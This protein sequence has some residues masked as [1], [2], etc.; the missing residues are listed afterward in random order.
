MSQDRPNI[1]L[2]M[3]DE[4]DPGVMG[5]YGDKLGAT[6]HLDQLASNGIVFDNAYCNSPLC[7]P[8][9]LSFTSGRYVSRVGAWN[10]HCRL[11]SDDSPS[12]AHALNAA[13][14]QSF[15]CGKQHYDKRHSYGFQRL[16]PGIDN[17]TM[18]GQGGFRRAADDFTPDKESW[19]QRAR[20]IRTGGLD[21]SYVLRQDIPV[22]HT[23]RGFLQAR[24]P[25]D[26][27]FFLMAGFIAPHFPLIVPESLHRQ[28]AG[29][30]PMPNLPEDFVER[31]PR[32]YRH[33]RAGF[34]LTEADEA[35][36]RYGRELYWALVH[37]VD[38]LVGQLLASLE[39]S[40]VADNTV[41]IYTSDHGENKG[42]H[43][44]WWKNSMHEQSARV[45]LLVS[46]PK[47]WAGGQRRAS[48][49]S[50]VD[51]VRTLLDLGKAGDDGVWDGD[52]LLPVLDDHG[53]P[54]KNTALSEYYGHNIASGYTLFRKDHWKYVYHTAPDD[55]HP[56]EYELYDLT[57]DP[58]EWNNLANDPVQRARRDRLHQAM[59]ETLGESPDA[60]EARCRASIAK[61]Y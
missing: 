41:V 30:V 47:R 42:D 6:P 5:C 40:R 58:G 13:G 18:T 39:Q 17:H 45:P 32:N 57:A 61:G 4:H 54:W 37:W 59:L 23:A 60:I 46:W 12:L 52:S 9:R 35:T 55:Q 8:S 25:Q 44:L 22:L 36:T 53:A 15:L 14:Y 50:L 27:P 48:V 2:I 16:V 33:L 38:G 26:A 11:P 1:L 31:L 49:C 56:P 28:F 3:S 19:H 24:S 7:V 43:G 10:N 34:G 21:D 29:R 51:V 20:D